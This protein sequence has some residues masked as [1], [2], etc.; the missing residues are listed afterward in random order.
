MTAI[1]HPW[2]DERQNASP[3]ATTTGAAVAPAR[4][5]GVPPS[6]LVI[7]DR[8]ISLARDADRAGCAVTA[9]RLIRLAHTVLDE[10]RR[11]C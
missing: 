5:L 6:P 8:L 9:G 1:A 7:C 10:P 11:V 3:A 2:Q 4:M